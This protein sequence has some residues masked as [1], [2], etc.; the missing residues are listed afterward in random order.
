[1]QFTILLL[2]FCSF[3]VVAWCMVPCSLER[4]MRVLRLGLTITSDSRREEVQGHREPAEEERQKVPGSSDRS[5]GRASSRRKGSEVKLCQQRAV[6]AHTAVVTARKKPIR[7]DLLRRPAR[8]PNR[9]DHLARLSLPPRASG[10]SASA[11]SPSFLPC[12][13]RH[14]GNNHRSACA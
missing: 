5:E 4:V 6:L 10:H 11:A 3:F 9:V 2:L 8:S 1:V 7:V 12:D 14:G 13:R